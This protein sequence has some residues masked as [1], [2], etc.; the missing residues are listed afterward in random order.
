MGLGVEVAVGEGSPV[1]VAL[2][3]AVRVGTGEGVA[4]GEGVIVRVRVNVGAIP[5]SGARLTATRPR[6]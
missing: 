6:Q 5:R 4:V 1:G 2:G 3:M